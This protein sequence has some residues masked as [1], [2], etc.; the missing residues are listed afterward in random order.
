VLHIG[1]KIVPGQS[2][3]ICHTNPSSTARSYT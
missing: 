2:N 1:N 3:V